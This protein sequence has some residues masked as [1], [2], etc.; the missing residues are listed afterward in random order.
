MSL[1]PILLTGL[2]FI[3]FSCGNKNNIPD[4]VLPPDKMKMVLWDVIKADA[5]ATEWVKRDSSRNFMEQS[6]KL[7]KNIFA[8]HNISKALF[9][10]SFNFYKSHPA[11]MSALM[12]SL[13][14]KAYQSR[15][16][17]KPLIPSIKDSI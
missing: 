7:Q 15:P 5:I 12:D 4:N 17:I 16:E 9:D 14:N 10:K 2:L 11:M 8:I 1:H 6:A 3:S 13:T